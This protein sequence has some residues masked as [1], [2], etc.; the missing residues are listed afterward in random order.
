MNDKT[1]TQTQHN[2]EF[3][4]LEE[5]IKETMERLQVPGVAIGMLHEGKEY[6][7]GLGVTNVEHPLP[8]DSKTLF[9]IGSLTKT[10][11]GT[12]V[13]R[14][15]EMGLLDLDLPLRTYLPD[16]KLAD[17]EAATRVTM[18]HLLTHTA[19]WAGDY[20]DNTGRGDDALARIV[21][22][23]ARLPQLT[24]PGAF[25]GYNNAAFYLAGRIIE[26]LTGKT[27]EEAVKELVLDA[28]EMSSSCFFAE[29]AITHRVAVGHTLQDATPE[30]AR[31]W[32]LPRAAHPA[33]GLVSCIADLL[34]YLHFHM[35]DGNASDGESV[36][37]AASI[38]QMQTPQL[39]E[40]FSSSTIGLTWWL[41]EIDGVRIVE[42][43]GATMGQQ[44]LLLMVPAMH[45]AIMILT[46]ATS[47]GQLCE[48]V[49][50]WA[51]RHYL[52]LSESEII[53]FDLPVEQLTPYV[54]QYSD[55]FTPWEVSIVDD[56]LMLQILPSSARQSGF[57]LLV[58]LAFCGEDR[59]LALDT[60]FKG[61]QGDFLRSADGQI[62]WLRFAGRIAARHSTL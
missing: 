48:E 40:S 58:P 41:R 44:A 38:A 42:H 36:L 29:E 6:V 20:F 22:N 15:V 43:S 32:A 25:W 34:R 11:T 26:V 31:S 3:H 24:E 12:A 27:Y 46:N 18:R 1:T 37:T 49:T 62:K 53:P 57:R 2:Q 61:T 33:G 9:Q 16:L 60:H 50:K 23:M 4:P 13:M 7:A 47:G 59:V 8:V 54:G 45:F 55:S 5:M 51:L 14:L 10:V 21:A 52:T 19:G 28:L 17:E 30:V 35:R 56:R 39:R